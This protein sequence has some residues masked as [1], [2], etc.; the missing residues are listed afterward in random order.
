M[1]IES[2][3][4]PEKQVISRS[5]ET[6]FENLGFLSSPTDVALPTLWAALDLHAVGVTM[7]IVDRAH[8]NEHKE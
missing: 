4:I 3:R 7:S 8:I 5:S 6:Y 1:L 2:S